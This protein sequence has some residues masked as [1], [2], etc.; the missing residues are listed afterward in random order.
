MVVDVLI[1]VFGDRGGRSAVVASLGR[2]GVA[3]RE[4]SVGCTIREA[5][6]AL[7]ATVVGIEVL[8]LVAPPDDR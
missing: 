3:F 4:G 1:L 7:L 8:A 2:E 5:V 6:G